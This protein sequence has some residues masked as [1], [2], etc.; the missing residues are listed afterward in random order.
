MHAT[1][2]STATQ[3]PTQAPTNFPVHYPV[4][5]ATSKM[6]GQN[7][8]FTAP[9]NLHKWRI[10]YQNWDSI[11]PRLLP[12]CCSL[13]EDWI[14]YSWIPL[15]MALDL[16]LIY[17][18]FR[19]LKEM[20]RTNVTILR[21]LEEAARWVDLSRQIGECFRSQRWVWSNQINLNAWLMGSNRT[22]SAWMYLS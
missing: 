9:N 3:Q 13:T 21:K 15:T 6:N 19:C 10:H 18:V 11:S 22:P 2:S 7:T 17:F 5:N 12:T 4:P 1:T 8:W 20:A 14:W 16:T